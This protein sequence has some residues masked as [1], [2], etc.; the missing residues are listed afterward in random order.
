MD[1][2]E[3]LALTQQG[4]DCAQCVVK[5]FEDEL[6]EDTGKV[7]RSVSCMSMGLLQG[8]VCGGVLAALAL[9]GWKYGS[10]KPDYASQGLCMIKREQFFMEFRRIY[11]DITCPGIIKLD[12]RKNEDNIKANATGVYTEICPK[13]FEDVIAILKRILERSVKQ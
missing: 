10:E 4:Y 5:A 8:S 2:D 13:L 12:V 9:I 7:I 11:G 3:L 6:G 1:R